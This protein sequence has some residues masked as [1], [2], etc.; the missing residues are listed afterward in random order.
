MSHGPL[1]SGCFSS[2]GVEMAFAWES[3]ARAQKNA[4]KDSAN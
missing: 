2:I 3:S 1:A 4:R